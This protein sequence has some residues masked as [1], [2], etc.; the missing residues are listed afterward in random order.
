MRTILSL[1]GTNLKLENLFSVLEGN[2]CEIN[3][4][5]GKFEQ[6]GEELFKLRKSLIPE[7]AS[8]KA[9]LSIP[10]VYAECYGELLPKETGMLSLFLL[11]DQSLKCRQTLR[12]E[13]IER[14]MG[15][16]NN[17][18][19]PCIHK[20]NRTEPSAMSELALI[21]SGDENTLCCYDGE[22]I[23]VEKALKAT[24]LSKFQY[25][26]EEI[27]FI[28]NL[29]CISTALA[30]LALNEAEKLAKTADICVGMNLEAIRGETGAFDRRL[31][32][33]GRPF[34]NR[35]ISAENIRRVIEGSEFTTEKARIAFGGDHGP[36]CQDAI[37]IRAVPQTHGGVRDTIQWLKENLQNE[38]NSA[39][40]RI[41]PIIGYS[42]DLMLIALTDLGNI[43]ERRSF[44][45]TD[46]NLTYGLPMNLVGE[47]P[48]FNHGF[49]VIQA[50]ATA[51]LGELK[52]LAMPC[53]AYS[54]IDPIS[55]E[56]VCKT[57]SSAIKAIEALSLLNK[58][59]AIEMLMAAQGMD[60]AKDK[61]TGFEFG[62]GSKAALLEFRK[63]VKV[64]RAN[65]FAA[66]DMVEADRI[67]NEGT[68]LAAVEKTVGKLM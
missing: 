6:P 7:E 13:F 33:L 18:I 3:L 52:L 53:A 66:P 61:L 24:G 55:K 25:T 4:V 50:S 51:V 32:E 29:C 28:T 14:I 49:P 38:I 42:I 15:F 45:L 46:T 41:N 31:H 44:R 60:L 65:R 17:G 21:L 12:A 11:L 34:P 8:E 20:A 48:G 56:Y 36:R 67:V 23:S 10:E 19:Y 22:C 43:S 30:I 40:Y 35:I 57:Y 47:N 27:A 1:D 54:G 59:L 64:T 63:H 62:N 26:T 16:I 37:C 2:P 39:S 9:A 68:V 58:V 5:K